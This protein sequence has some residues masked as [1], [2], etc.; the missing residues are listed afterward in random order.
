MIREDRFLISRKPFAVDLNSLRVDTRTRS[1]GSHYYAGRIDAVWYRRRQGVTYACIG[2]LWN[3]REEPPAT[4]R[5]FLEDHTD[6][7][8]GG[9]C[10]G[11]WDGSR[12]WG[13]QEPD[14]VAEHLEILRPM[15]ANVPSMPH[16]FDGWWTF[17]P[18]RRT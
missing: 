17:Q 11:R 8:Y 9:D 18:A 15:V 6:G 12:Y 16:G 1:D 2:T 10:D 4:G 14:V 3:S 5:A 7:R 13:V